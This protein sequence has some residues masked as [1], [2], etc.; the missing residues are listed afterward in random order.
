[1][2]E[3]AAAAKAA[4]AKVAAQEAIAHK[5]AQRHRAA[6]QAHKA[7]RL[8]ADKAVAMLAE[9]KAKLATAETQADK[10]HVVLDMTTDATG[11]RKARQAVADASRRAAEADAHLKSVA[12]EAHAL[13]Q[14]TD[15][16]QEAVDQAKRSLAHARA[17]EKVSWS[18]ARRRT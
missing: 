7:A 6:R 18:R 12:T 13:L 4:A 1:M 11:A 5:A 16:S 14:E 15:H 9:L 2:R 3:K 10:A 17:A 8:K